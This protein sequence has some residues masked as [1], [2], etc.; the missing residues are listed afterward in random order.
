MRN[1]GRTHDQLRPVKITRNYIKHAEGSCLIEVGDTKVICTATLEDRVP[2]FMRGGGKGWITAEYAMLPRATESRN[3]RESSKGKVAGR[4]M[5]IQRLIGRAL[6]SVVQLEAMGERTIWLDCDVIQA[7]GGTRTASITGAYVAMVEAMSKLV[8]NG[9]WKQ[10]PLND[11]LAATSVGI[12][13]GEVLLD[14]NYKEDSTATVDMNI[15]MTGEGKFVELQGTGEEAPFSVEQLQELLALAKKGI[16]QLFA[17]QREALSELT[18]SFENKGE[19]DQE[20][21]A[22]ENHV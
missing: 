13:D 10:Y 20:K 17:A 3:A 2:P 16:D 1:D 18:L 15:V 21:E 5:E 22:E 14:L 7:D 8:E 9:T 11:F 6:R 4:T 12:I 19:G